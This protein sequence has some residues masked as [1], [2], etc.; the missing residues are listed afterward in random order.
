MIIQKAGCLLLDPSQKAIALVYREKHKD[1]SLPKGHLEPG[2]TLATCAL[3]ETEEETGRLCALLSPDPAGVLTYTDGQ[4]C[5]VETTYF[6]AKDLGPSPKII[7]VELTH[8]L[9]WVPWDHVE[10]TLTYP[11]LKAF[12]H[13]LPHPP[14]DDR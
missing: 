9:V 5:P 10:Q 11:N 3:R 14:R 8:Q 1:Y 2:E 13:T 12:F 4:G 7:P 6:W